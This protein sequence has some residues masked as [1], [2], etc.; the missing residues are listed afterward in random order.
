MTGTSGDHGYGSTSTGGLS[1]RDWRI[2][3][4]MYRLMPEGPRTVTYEDI[5]VQAWKLYPDKFGLRGYSNDY[6]DAS[7]IHKP[8]YNTLKSRGWVSTGPK[9]AKKFS[10]T[11]SGWE[12]AHAALTGRAALRAS[13]GRASR[14]TLDEIEHLERA[15]AVGMYLE[16]RTVDILD[17]DFFAFYRTSV[18]AGAQEF[19]GRLAEVAHALDE[20]LSLNVPTAETL[21]KVDDFLR[22]RFAEIIDAKSE[23]KKRGGMR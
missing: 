5:V 7:D 18:R 12:R 15:E 21:S 17:T 19:E 1:P 20:A 23:R 8:L 9:G 11:S 3:E 16:G 14:E 22:K 6:P 2:V 10:L 4:A 13:A